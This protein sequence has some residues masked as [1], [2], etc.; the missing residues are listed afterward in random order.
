[1]FG[2]NDGALDNQQIHAGREHRR[3]QV[4]GVLRGN[5]DRRGHAAVPNLPDPFFDQVLPHRLGIDFL[6]IAGGTVGFLGDLLE[7][8][9]SGSE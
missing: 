4:L 9:G 7:Q 8:R 5:P 6:Q 3:G 2:R 1:M